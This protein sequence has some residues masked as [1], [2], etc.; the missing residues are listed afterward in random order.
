MAIPV[1]YELFVQ[2]FFHWSGV[3]VRPGRRFEHVSPQLEF[4]ESNWPP[5]LDPI[6]YYYAI[7]PAVN[8]NATNIT[9]E[10]GLWFVF[11]NGSF[12]HCSLYNAT[13]TTHV[14][15]T[16]NLPVVETNITHHQQITDDVENDYDNMLPDKAPAGNP[17]PC[18]HC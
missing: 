1:R 11:T 5:P 3:P 6:V 13:Y 8:G 12:I 4:Y 15:Y 9:A 2:R 18:V 10:Q 14:N 17:K 7:D 16:N